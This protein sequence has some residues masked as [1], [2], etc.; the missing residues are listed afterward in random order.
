MTKSLL[1]EFQ[2]ISESFHGIETLI[3]KISESTGALLLAKEA[4][5][6][7]SI[8]ELANCLKQQ[9]TW[10]SIPTIVLLSSGDLSSAVALELL[11]PLPNVTLLERPIRQRA[12]QSIV[13]SALA[14]RKRQWDLRDSLNEALEANRAKSAFLA[15]MSHEIRTPLGAILGFSD[16]I[17]DAS[18][19]ENDRRLYLDTIHRNG[20][21]LTALINDILDLAKVE[22]GKLNIELIDVSL[23]ELLADVVTALEP[24]AS[25]KKVSFLLE[26]NPALP[27][28][29]V[30]DPVRLKQILLNILGNAI[31]FTNRGSV[32]LTVGLKSQSSGTGKRSLLV[33]EVTDTGVGIKPEQASLLF[34][35]FTQA[36]VSITRKFGGTGLGLV[37]SQK[38]ARA[39]GGDLVLT[40]SEYGVGST[41]EIT[42]ARNDHVQPA[43]QNVLALEQQ[44][45]A[46][47]LKGLRVLVVDDSKDNQL[48][49]MKLLA[50]FGVETSTA[51]NGAEGVD[52]ALALNPDI[53]LMDIQMPVLSGIDA[54]GRLRNA[55][56][57]KP[58]IALTA[59]ALKGDRE[60]CLQAGCSDY[61]TKPVQKSDLHLV[62]ARASRLARKH[63]SMSLRTH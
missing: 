3:S 26:Q 24:K 7:R 6:P 48:L 11:A 36:D 45:A 16:L 37:L 8:T 60:Q 28:T 52:K 29:V 33:F 18:I 55:G 2:V 20:Q 61:L 25:A 5:S 59:H 23:R 40:E 9:P 56:F 54:A 49:L 22:A 4:L 57:E 21:L 50:A 19:T 47:D 62:L 15:N 13:Q 46:D 43:M 1:A 14:D 44:L 53:V 30:T 10:S 17:A 27:T 41:F 38:L 63:G 42:I 35:P 51:D 12:L 58:I 39:L 31:K 34:Q 32:K